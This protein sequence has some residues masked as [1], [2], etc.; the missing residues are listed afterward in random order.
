[1]NEQRDSNPEYTAVVLAGDRGPQD[2]VAVATG[3]SCK[4][5]SPVAGRPMILRVLAALGQSA[6]V[7]KIVLSGPVRPH[8][9]QSPPLLEG[10]DAD[11][12]TWLA[13][14][15]TPSTSA[16]AALETVPEQ[17]PVLLTTADHA[18]LRHE[19]VDF[20]CA[21][22]RR[23]GCDLA[24]AFVTHQ[25]VMSAFPGMR[26]TASRFRDGAFCGCNLFAFMSPE[27]RKAAD[28]WCRVEH[29][30]KH[31]WRMIRILGWRPLMG[32][33]MRRL[34]L[35]ATLE[36]LGQRLGIRICPILLPFPEAAV[37]VDKPADHEA[38]ERILETI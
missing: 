8:L 10:I 19:I 15:A 17:T 20:F 18:L 12:W 38:V 33:L 37:D 36:T 35:E 22:A 34:T 5:L 3:A 14:A 28:F 4:A 23:E 11:R 32:Y 30:R 1:M 27:A 16:Y 13:P 24:V 29:Q 21:A 26:R 25:Q 9:E 2:P 7:G 31:P 6:E